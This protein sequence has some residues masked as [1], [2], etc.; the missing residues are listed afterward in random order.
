MD[1]D[2][3]NQGMLA[4]CPICDTPSPYECTGS[5]FLDTVLQLRPPFVWH[6]P[7]GLQGVT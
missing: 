5:H 3:N 2:E 7:G 4:K 1:Q 6:K